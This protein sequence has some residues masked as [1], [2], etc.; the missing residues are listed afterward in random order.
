MSDVTPVVPAPE[1]DW[2]V[3]VR[4]GFSTALIVLG[5]MWTALWPILEDK[6]ADEGTVAALLPPRYA[7]VATVVSGLLRVYANYKKQTK[8]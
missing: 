1:Y 2:K 4:K 7:V 6:F 3:G 5:A 8:V